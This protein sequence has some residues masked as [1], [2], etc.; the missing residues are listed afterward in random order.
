MIS[1]PVHTCSQSQSLDR[2][3]TQ[4][5]GISGFELMTRAGTGAF[6]ECQ[7][8]WPEIRAVNVLCGSGNNGGDGYI[9]ASS[10]LSRGYSAK[11]FCASEPKTES[12]RQARDEFV[13]RRGQV[14]SLISFD[15]CRD[16]ELVVDALFGSGLSRD[17]KYPYQQAV[18]SI[19]AQRSPVL[20]LDM[21][22]GV[23]G[24][25]GAVLGSAVCADLTVTFISVKAGLLMGAGKQLAGQLVLDRL[26]VPDDAYLQVD[27]AA[28]QICP[29]E[30]TQI[31]P[32]RST[33]AHKYDAGKVTIVGGAATMQGAALMAAKAAYCTGAGLVSV[34]MPTPAA[35]QYV[36]WLPEARIFDGTDQ[37]TAKALISQSSAAG[38]GPG[39][40][41]SDW[42]REIVEWIAHEKL[43]MA[44]DADALGVLAQCNL[45]SPCWVLTPHHGEA[46][47]LLGCSSADVR[48]DRL[49]AARQIAAQ[50]GG[51]CILKGAGS[52]V[53]DG[54]NLWICDRGNAGM[55]TAGMGDVLTGAVSALLAQG[56]APAAAARMAVWLHASAGD[57]C[58]AQSGAV[59]M[60]ATNLFAPM[61]LRLNELINGAKI[62]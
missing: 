34:V 21:P 2:I 43:P 62:G 30:L 26:G 41:L 23:N 4:E 20:A 18:E 15:G 8:K 27:R 35:A 31:A 22:S 6:R 7:R 51:V 54:E 61:R 1:P 38:I 32:R 9:L 52:V 36:A 44:V 60:I 3:V 53:C 55:A 50:Y 56:L 5:W 39:M 37:D 14:F 13:D 19:N 47:R 45:H 59:G 24:D 42:T 12:A 17:I 40:G 49:G 16:N 58:A 33:D 57:D 25:T 46:A 29:A 10:A 48:S 11:V 28:S